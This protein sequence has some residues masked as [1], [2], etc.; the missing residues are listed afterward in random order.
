[1]KYKHS[2]S[3]L[4][5]YLWYLIP[6]IYF[7]LRMLPL[8]Q[9]VKLPI[10]LIRP[11]FIKLKGKI[12]IDDD[13]CRFGLVKMGG[14]GCKAYPNTGIKLNLQGGTWTIKGK[15]WIGSNSYIEIGHS[16]AL[17]TGDKVVA[18][19]SLIL[20]CSRN[21]VLGDATRFGWNCK[22]MDTSFHPLKN[23]ETGERKPAG[24]P[25]RIGRNN[26]FATDCAILPGTTTADDC[27]FGYGCVLTKSVKT[28]SYC[29]HGGSP[30]HVLSRGYYRTPEEEG[31]RDPAVWSQALL[32]LLA[33]LLPCLTLSSC[34][35]EDDSDFAAIKSALSLDFPDDYSQDVYFHNNP[36]P[37]N[38]HQLR[39][40]A[41]GNSYTLDATALVP[42]ILK[43][44]GVD[45]A[46]YSLYVAHASRAS[47]N[48]W[49]D[50]ISDRRVFLKRRGGLPMPVVEGTMAE[51][52][53]QPWD[54][55]TF[56]QY[57]G[58]AVDYTTFNPSLRFLIDYACSVCPNPRLSFAWQMVWSYVDGYTG[59][60][61]NYERWLLIA[62]AAKQMMVQD[63][64]N[65]MIPLGTAIQNARS[66]S[67]NTERQLTRDGTHL[68]YEMGRYIAACTFVQAV[69]A[70]V[71]GLDIKAENAE[72]ADQ[73]LGWQC[74]QAAVEHPFSITVVK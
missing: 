38:R 52:L 56:Q 19:T 43:E 35:K 69:F 41:I 32:L 1:M 39:V 18:S 63:G 66:T 23:V 64:I 51:L 70:P 33:F 44:H 5:P 6:T 72:T 31:D 54:V 48:Y 55:I 65:V 14:W 25:I 40:L 8:R 37:V 24:A 60:M 71:Y 27:V 73:V 22:V 36:L 20:F 11:K 53:S 26:W 15:T 46:S 4:L 3:D 2:I 67:L 62:Y 13:L 47:L 42:K 9:A 17:E 7:N 68:D 50:S 21:V 58:D 16:G 30:V 74:A 61:S 10:L 45:T 59:K 34:S 12:V 49:A 29:V 57:S 28:E